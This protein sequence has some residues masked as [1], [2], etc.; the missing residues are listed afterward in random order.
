MLDEHSQISVPELPDIG[1]YADHADPTR[2]YAVPKAPRVARD[3]SGQLA[4]SLLLYGRGKGPDLQLMGGQVMVTLTLGLTGAE[5]QTLIRALELPLTRDLAQ[6]APA[7]RVT[8][9]SP[10][11]LAGEAV[12]DLMPGLMLR[13]QP[14]LMAANECVLSADLDGQRAGELQTAWKAGLPNARL[15]YDLT[16]S[17]AVVEEQQSSTVAA[18][19]S[20]ASASAS[21]AR[22][23]VHA[24]RSVH[25]PLCLQ[26]PLLVTPADLQ[27]SL[28]ITSF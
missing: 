14:S 18:Q 7:P 1:V 26:G 17:A 5:R 16:I 12:A 2:Y 8:L 23:T 11:W 3:E 24:T 4:L 28:Q 20:P 22:Y 10:D 9:L 13:G 19:S 25:A 6:G 21:G 27:G 15:T